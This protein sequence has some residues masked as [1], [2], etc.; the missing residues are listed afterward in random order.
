MTPKS[1]IGLNALAGL[2]RQ[3]AVSM[4]STVARALCVAV[5]TASF[6]ASPA[7]AADDAAQLSKPSRALSAP[8]AAAAPIPAKSESLATSASRGANFEGE[9]ASEDARQIADWIVSSGDNSSM[10]FAIVDKKEAKVFIFRADGQLRGAAPALLGLAIGDDSVPGIGQRAMSGIS[11]QERTTPAGRFVAALDRTLHG[12]QVLW[13]DYDN[14]IAMH[15]VVTTNPQERR[16]QRLESATPADHRI[17][18][19]C[20]NVPAQFFKSVVLRAFTGTAGIVYVLPETRSP[21]KVF[22]SFDVEEQARLRASQPAPA[23]G[24]SGSVR[25]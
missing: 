24:A 16:L 25:H 11:P 5:L 4:H 1:R 14:A 20:I 15:P 18:Y 9:H 2:S 6:S 19:G 17:S 3:R 23:H 22:A 8:Q 12:K 21:R 13:V 10:P 7:L